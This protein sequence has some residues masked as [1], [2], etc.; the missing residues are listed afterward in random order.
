LALTACQARTDVVVHAA[1]DGTG[2]VEVVVALD[3]EAAARVA[4]AKARTDDLAKAGWEVHPVEREQG[5]GAV[6]RVEKPFRSPDEAARVLR[7]VSADGGPLRDVRLVRERSFL[8]TRTRLTGALDLSAG[9]AAF[10][11]PELTQQLG[12]QPVGVD[13]ARV[14]PLEQALRLSL[15]AELPGGTKRWTVRPGQR[16]AVAT[17]AEQWNVLSIALAVVAVLALVGF[18]VSV[19]RALRSQQRTRPL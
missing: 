2:R 19:R 12:G 6:Y 7:E 18:A 10:G 15:V 14:T 11:D 9:A 1:P 3:K 17:V 4:G 8:K 5:G 16:V 13:A